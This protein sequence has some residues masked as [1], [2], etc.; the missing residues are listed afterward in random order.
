M[1][2]ELLSDIRSRQPDAAIGLDVI[3]GFP[4][5]TDQQFGNTL[6]FLQNLP[7]THLHVFP[8]SRRPGTP[9]ATMKGQLPGNIIKQRAAVLRDLGER[10]LAE[11]SQKFIGRELEIIIE[12]GESDGHCKGLSENYLNLTVPAGGV[13]QGERRQVKITSERQATLTGK[14]V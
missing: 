8:F 6:N 14:I 9:A 5:E 12:G 11:F 7:F 3:T 13:T 2:H 10:K 1:F 4:G